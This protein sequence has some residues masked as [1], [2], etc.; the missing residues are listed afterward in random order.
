[1]SEEDLGLKFVKD[2][3]KFLDTSP[4]KEPKQYFDT[5]HEGEGHFELTSHE[6]KETGAEQDETL[7]VLEP[8]HPLLK[9]FQIALKEHL[10]RQIEHL[11]NEI[12]EYETATKKMQAEK[13]QLGTD[14]YEIQQVVSKQQADLENSITQLQNVVAAREETGIKLQEALGEH[15]N[16]RTKL[17]ETE[18]KEIELRKEM[19]SINL[20]MQ[21]MS[22]WEADIESE[23]KVNQ[24]KFEKTKKD[25]MKL[26]E[27]KRNQDMLVYKLMTEIWDLEADLETI[28]MQLRVKEEER[29]K[30]AETVVISNTDIEAA[31]SEHRCLLHGWHSVIIAISSRDKHLSQVSQELSVDTENLR[32]ILSEI[33]QI[34]KLCQREMNKNETLTMFKNRIETDLGNARHQLEVEDNKRENLERTVMKTKAIIDQT[35]ADIERIVHENQALQQEFDLLIK[36]YEKAINDKTNLDATLLENLQIQLTNDKAC[37]YLNKVLYDVKVKN[38]AMQI[39]LG[40]AENHNANVLMDIECQKGTNDELERILVDLKKQQ[41]IVDKQISVYVDEINKCLSAVNKKQRDIE[42]LT[43]KL[44]KIKMSGEVTKSP[45]ELKI[46]ALE[47]HIEHVQEKIKD[48]QKFW[49]R[50]QGHVVCLSE[51]REEQIHDRNLLRK[52]TLILEQRN[53]K[54]NDELEVHRKQEEKMR[55]NINKLQNQLVYY[56]EALSKK[57][58]S[59]HNLDERNTLLQNEF[60]FKLKEEE[61]SIVKIEAEIVDIEQ[62]MSRLTAELLEKNREALEWEKKMK[63]VLET[64]QNI[65]IEKGEGGEV[66]TMRAEIHRMNVRYSQLK[67]AQDKLILDLEHCVSRRDAIVTNAEA[68]EKKIGALVQSKMIMSR[69]LDDLKNKVK[70]LETDIE[71]V[72][73]TI[74]DV[75]YEFKLAEN[76]MVVDEHDIEASKVH[77]AETLRQIDEI[78]TDKQLVSI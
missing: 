38:R 22:N 1:M 20:L 30:L 58:G 29:E 51:Q 64:K 39:T 62:D 54:I 66:S 41:V 9:K 36:N 4:E 2:A 31:E 19:D 63:M 40:N 70:V 27:E 74:T 56:T 75:D 55:R 10:E 71:N 15:K 46:S 42:V 57:Q 37:R 61:L 50:E 34:K 26:A 28:L 48:M 7:K 17:Y 12:F 59:K 47:Q 68:R 11:K 43:N 72:K 23:L 3:F 60:V 77:F 76:Q 13:D 69:K 33:E 25:K 67:K 65:N 53:L 16:C 32:S 8:E 52:Q 35:E 5:N 21:Q 24:R 44:E 78:K 49:L 14:T 45:H 73:R 18:K 6:K